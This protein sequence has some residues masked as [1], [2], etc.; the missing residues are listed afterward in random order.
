MTPE[1]ETEDIMAEQIEQETRQPLTASAALTASGRQVVD[2]GPSLRS[3]RRRYEREIAELTDRYE[4]SLPV[5]RE[6]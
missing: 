4:R 3:Y 6:S 1:R 5:L 2:P